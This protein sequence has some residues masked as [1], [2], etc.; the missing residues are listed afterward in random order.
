VIAHQ[1]QHCELH[2]V[3]LH[4]R[5]EGEA[6][7]E[8]A[9]TLLR[10]FRRPPAATR[11]SHA[12]TATVRSAADPGELP[13][14]RSSAAKLA[15][16]QPRIGFDGSSWGYAVWREQGRTI[17]EVSDR[18]LVVVEPTRRRADAW[19]VRPGTWA[20]EER[21]GLVFLLASEILRASG[22]YP[23]HASA[24][25]RD[26]RAVL[27]LGSSGAGK[28][29]CLLSLMQAGW[30]CLSDDHPLVCGTDDGP[31][32]LPWPARLEM[33]A[34]TPARFG[35]LGDLSTRVGERKLWLY[36]EELG[37][38]PARAPARPALLL[39]PKVVDWPSSSVE[40]VS[41]R[42]ALE[43][44]LRLGMTVVHRDAAARQFALLACL[45][46]ETARAR[47]FFGS[48][49]E[50]LPARVDALIEAAVA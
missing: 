39:F 37:A 7:S 9:A 38:G 26:G 40:P 32:V 6:M 34:E 31:R 48:D 45:A 42:F 49:V 18:G 3:S 23:L 14:A 33:T 29:T 19:A 12:W 41:A 16:E 27:I 44:L 43:E 28:S 21:E 20:A 4:L 5:C 30:R 25:E 10:S 36:P 17:I 11:N 13:R 22:L 47:L 8:T 24:A 15:F 1:E 46:R 2:G 35:G 50:R